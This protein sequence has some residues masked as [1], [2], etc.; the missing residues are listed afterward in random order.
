MTFKPQGTTMRKL[1]LTCLGITGLGLGGAVVAQSIGSVNGNYVH[2]GNL[3]RAGNII[4]TITMS[5]RG[6]NAST[7]RAACDADNQCWAYTF[8][9]TA[10]NRKPECHL[11][12]TA[13]PQAAKRNHGYSQ[14]VSGTK[15]RFLPDV[16]GLN[17]YPA[18]TI[19]G[20]VAKGS[21]KVPNQDP[22]AC[23]DACYRDGTCS[24]FT[25]TPPT[26]LPKSAPA[27]CTLH[28][29]GGTLSAKTVTGVLSGSKTKMSVPHGSRLPS[30]SGSAPTGR[31]TLTPTKRPVIQRPADKTITI[32]DET[33]EENPS[34]SDDD[35]AHFPGEMLD[36]NGG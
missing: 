14:A 10:T 35:D 23:A 22:I 24:S 11:R 4:T 26:R 15:L 13:L 18:R 12:L 3:V 1:I 20:A 25:Y 16:L 5:N 32:P 36:P 30:R 34:L 17:P 28:S 2:E 21:F 7:C 8:E 27:M 9:Q 19:E 31:P 29:K 33:P 6:Q